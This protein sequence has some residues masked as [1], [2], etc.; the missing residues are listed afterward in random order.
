M[1]TPEEVAEAL[2]MLRRHGLNLEGACWWCGRDVPFPCPIYT[3]AQAVLAAAE[4]AGALPDAA[5]TDHPGGPDRP[6][7]SPDPEAAARGDR[8]DGGAG[9]R[10]GSAAGHED[11]G[12]GA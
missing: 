6:D 12:P 9:A 4:V 10:R 11:A 3:A 7:R 2:A 5:G 8:A 1:P